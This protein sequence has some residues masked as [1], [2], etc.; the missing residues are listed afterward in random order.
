M[1]T[2]KLVS[3]LVL[4]AERECSISVSSSSPLSHTLEIILR[5]FLSFSGTGSEAKAEVTTLLPLI[6]SYVLPEFGKESNTLSMEAELLPEATT[7]EPT[8]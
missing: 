2:V 8:F 4:L 6:V 7:S 1:Y 3:L 5:S